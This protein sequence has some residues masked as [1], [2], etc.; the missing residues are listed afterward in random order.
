MVIAE[1]QDIGPCIVEVLGANGFSVTLKE[2]YLVSDWTA[3]RFDLVIVTNT[4]LTPP[5]IRSTVPEIK[6][7]HPEV[8]I[9]VLSGYI[10][11]RWVADLKLNG[12]DR[13]LPLPFKIKALL[14]VVSGLLL[15]PPS[16]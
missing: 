16:D 13:F 5:E 4:S 8:R 3:R 7:G 10:D 9:M 12:V 14:T 1:V 2:R 15:T 6:S 11:E